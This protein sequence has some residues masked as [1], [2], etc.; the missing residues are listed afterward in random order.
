MFYQ[1]FLLQQVKRRAI[2]TYKLGDYELPH[3][4]PNDLRLKGNIRK[5]SKRHRMIA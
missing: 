2:I 3:Q 1:I 4:L 5:E